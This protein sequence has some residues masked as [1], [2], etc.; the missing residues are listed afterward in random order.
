MLAPDPFRTRE[1]PAPMTS[2]Q[3]QL[4][5]QRVKTTTM[6]V[7]S[8]LLQALLI[9][10]FAWNGTVSWTVAGWFFVLSVGSTNLFLLA[11]VQG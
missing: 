8:S 4:Q 11:V 6:T 7:V 5:A 9:G 10:L 1:S 3:P 2:Q